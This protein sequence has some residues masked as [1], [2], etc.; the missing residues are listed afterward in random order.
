MRRTDPCIPTSAVA[1]AYAAECSAASALS[2]ALV[3]T[4]C[5]E[6]TL[7][8]TVF[9]PGPGVVTQAL[10]S[11]IKWCKEDKSSFE[12]IMN[13][14]DEA[15]RTPEEMEYMSYANFLYSGVDGYSK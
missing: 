3:L 7:H 9:A 10:V 13:L 14:V 4:R 1:H 15:E 2:L 11:L 12:K 8:E 5:S 6:D